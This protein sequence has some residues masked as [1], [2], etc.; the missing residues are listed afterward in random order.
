MMMGTKSASWAHR[1]LTGWLDARALT[2]A[3]RGGKAD[4][5]QNTPCLDQIG[6]Q[7]THLHTHSHTQHNSPTRP[8]SLRAVHLGNTHTQCSR[9][10]PP[11]DQMS[12]ARGG[13]HPRFVS[14][15]SP[16]RSSCAAAAARSPEHLEH[17]DELRGVARLPRAE[18]R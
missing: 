1:Q 4:P 5:L 14:R 8:V 3:G 10:P 18:E 7:H 15:R 12:S 11:R 9:A 17:L 6:A 16:S 2:Q 13:E